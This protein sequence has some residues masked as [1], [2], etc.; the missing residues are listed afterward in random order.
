MRYL[1]FLLLILTGEVGSAFGS[2]ETW[3]VVTGDFRVRSMDLSRIDGQ[4]VVGKEQGRVETVDLESFVM[5]SRNARLEPPEG[6]VLCLAGGDRLIGQPV[7]LDSTHLTW[8]ASGIGPIRVPIEQALGI[9]RN[10][11]DDPRLTEVRNED[12]LSLSN[13]DVVRGI[14]TSV[15]ER[16]LKIAPAGADPIPMS[17][18]TIQEL[19]FATPP[20]GRPVSPLSGYVLRLIN[21]TIVSCQKLELKDNKLF[22]TLNDRSSSWIPVHLVV[23]IEHTSGP[24][25]WLSTRQP[26]EIIYIPYF[27]GNF[28]PVMDKTVTGDPIRMNGQPVLRGIGMHSHTRMTFPIQVGDRKFRSRYWIEPSLSYANVDVRI[29]LDGKVVHENKGFKAGDLSP[30]VDV[31]V[32]HGKTLTLEVDYGQGYDVQDRIVWVEPAII[33]E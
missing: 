17:V 6:L 29:Y 32:T 21:G 26:L 12:V 16:T 2:P 5:A 1:A 4:S 9:L 8:F 30:V 15:A 19:L 13:G 14:V 3:R 22:V 33:R 11:I 28:V 24:V 31:D 18:E 10:S 20:Q 7:G 25:Q 23:S 27:E